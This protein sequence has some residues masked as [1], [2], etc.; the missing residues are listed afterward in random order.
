MYTDNTVAEQHI[1]QE[2]Q[3]CILCKVTDPISTRSLVLYTLDMYWK[4]S[5]TKDIDC[6]SSNQYA[7]YQAGNQ[8]IHGLIKLRMKLTKFR[9]GA[10]Q[11]KENTKQFI[12]RDRS[13]IF[14]IEVLEH[15]LKQT[16]DSSKHEVLDMAPSTSLWCKD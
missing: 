10:E 6:V 12:I 4:S 2:E 16:R 8:N 5:A 13:D 3:G 7:N 14:K 15:D 11:T 1:Q 9:N